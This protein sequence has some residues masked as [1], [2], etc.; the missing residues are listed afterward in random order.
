LR[1]GGPDNEVRS[2]LAHVEAQLAQPGLRQ[3]LWPVLAVDSGFIVLNGPEA[4]RYMHNWARNT[5]G[6]PS[7]RR[8]RAARGLWM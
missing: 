5:D 7:G 1:P 4:L 3:A 6:A 2:S 8:V